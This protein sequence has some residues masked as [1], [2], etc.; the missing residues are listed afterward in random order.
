MREH[1]S[2]FEGL[3][4]ASGTKYKFEDQQAIVVRSTSFD[5]PVI[6]KYTGPGLFVLLSQ[7]LSFCHPGYPQDD[8]NDFESFVNAIKEGNQRGRG[9]DGKCSVEVR[10]LAH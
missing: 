6:I 4:I 10:A 2:Y 9:A 1:A 3:V 8:E 5:G 7:E